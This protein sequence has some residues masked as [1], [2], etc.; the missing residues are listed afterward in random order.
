[1]LAVARGGGDLSADNGVPIV[2]SREGMHESVG[3]LPVSASELEET[4][5][6]G[7]ADVD[8]LTMGDTTELAALAH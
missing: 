7:V 3:M 2:E 6:G 8:E 5:R 1:M 4:D